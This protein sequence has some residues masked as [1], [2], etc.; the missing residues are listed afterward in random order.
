MSEEGVKVDEKVDEKE[1]DVRTT[2]SRRRIGLIFSIYQN[3]DG[4]N[5]EPDRTICNLI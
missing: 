3:W 4:S 1:A 5:L 2:R